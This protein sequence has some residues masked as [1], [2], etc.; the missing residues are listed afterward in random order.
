MFY[1]GIEECEVGSSYVQVY[2]I[3]SISLI[4]SASIGKIKLSNARLVS[5]VLHHSCSVHTPQQETCDSI[6][7]GEESLCLI[8]ILC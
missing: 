7:Y 6:S 8:H 4:L 3:H 1:I 2:L 5:G